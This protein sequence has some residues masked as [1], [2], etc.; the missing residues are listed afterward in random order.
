M[1]QTLQFWAGNP[2]NSLV[3]GI[4]KI[5]E[6]SSNESEKVTS[7]FL[8]C[9]SIPSYL[10]VFEFC[11]FLEEQHSRYQVVDNQLSL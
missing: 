7:Q 5:S 4:L 8:C 9:P 1:S 6:I 3:H 2:R 11:M 10:H